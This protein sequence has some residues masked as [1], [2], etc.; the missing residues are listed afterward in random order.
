MMLRRRVLRTLILGEGS[1]AF[2]VFISYAHKDKLAADAACNFLERNQIRCW[3]APR[4]ITPGKDYAEAILDAIAGAKVMV[5]IFSGNA[6]TSEQIKR[7]VERAVNKRLPII[8]LRIEGVDPSRSLEYFISTSHWLDAF[9]PPLH[10]YFDQLVASVRALIGGVAKDPQPAPPVPP[11]KVIRR[12]TP[13]DLT[14]WTVAFA[15]A[16]VGLV[17]ELLNQLKLYGLSL[18][19]FVNLLSLRRVLYVG[20][21]VL[22]AAKLTRMPD[23]QRLIGIAAALYVLE[24]IFAAV[25]LNSPYL[26][27]PWHAFEMLAEWLFVARLFCTLDD[28]AMMGI[29]AAFGVAQWMVEFVLSKTLDPSLA[30]FLTTIFNYSTT[31]LCIAYGIQRQS[32]AK[33]L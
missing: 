12:D 25:H 33:T 4:D 30:S 29:A 8:P 5:L 32:A 28:K 11:P 31:A 22:V 24:T 6:N 16:G 3:M 21:I 2:D 19:G 23:V 27:A 10:S 17:A 20:G 14:N 9:P 26:N 13:Q 15:A 18:G 1:L 7:E